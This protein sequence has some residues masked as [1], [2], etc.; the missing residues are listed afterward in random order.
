M[1]LIKDDTIRHTVGIL[2]L[3]YSLSVLSGAFPAAISNL[4]VSINS[5]MSRSNFIGIASNSVNLVLLISLAA[6]G[7]KL[8]NT[9]NGANNSRLFDE[10]VVYG[11]PIMYF[12]L[13]SVF[14]LITDIY[15][16]LRMKYQ[17]AGAKLFFIN[18][19]IWLFTT[20]AILLT[21]YV[22]IRS[23]RLK[24]KSIF[25]DNTAR[26]SAGSLLICHN[27]L[28][29]ANYVSINLFMTK[30]NIELA[31]Q[32]GLDLAPLSFNFGFGAFLTV[33][34][35]VCGILLFIPYT[36]ETVELF[37]YRISK[38]NPGNRNKK[39]EYQADEWTSVSDIG[40]LFNGQMLDINT[41]RSAEDTYINA[42]ALLMRHFGLNTMFISGLEKDK[43]WDG[44]ETA[45]RYPEL[46]PDNLEKTFQT[47]EE[48]GE[49]DFDGTLAVCRLLLRE[50]LRCDLYSCEKGFEI[51]VGY[52]FY[53]KV[54][55]TAISEDIIG[56]IDRMGLYVETMKNKDNTK[57]TIHQ[58]SLT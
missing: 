54:R 52:D 17:I 30:S 9:G 44:I 10:K 50:D 34:Q 45:K 8:K 43:V 55:S 22:L 15:S 7:Y 31:Q 42:V 49:L 32:S 39:G 6:A 41:Y 23:N 21:L 28:S 25:R 46:Y 38:Y 4:L 26:N 33:C 3:I 11:L 29:L 40:K 18:H 12:A 57:R 53:I 35:I 47:A 19:S 2:V 20:A 36:K 56:E 48:G 13:D 51:I 27:F 58:V 1:P 14:T 16:A 5:P 37:L 24:L